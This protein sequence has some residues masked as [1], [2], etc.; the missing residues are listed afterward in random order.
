MIHHDE[1]HAWAEEAGFDGCGITPAT[2]LVE[3]QQ[4]FDRWL[5]AGHHA[6]LDYLTRH[7]D[8]RF[9]PSLLI[10]GA[11]SVVVCAVS[12]KNTIS[13]GYPASSRT[14]VA[15]YACNRDYHHTFKAMLQALLARIRA[16]HPEVTGRAF[17][18]TAPLAE[19]S[20]A[21]E[22]GLGW[23][24]RNSLLISP[25]WGSFL[26]LGELV[27]TTEADRYDRPFGE[28][29]C[30][31]CRACIEHCP[32]GAILD[33]ERMIDASRCIACHT[34][35]RQPDHAINLDGWIFGC[36]ACQ[37]PC[38][39]NRHAPHHR[40]SQF[41]PLFDPRAWDAEAW[42]QLDDAAFAEHFGSTP[43][44][45]AGLERIRENSKQ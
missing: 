19:K 39:Y 2:R 42:Q 37:Q 21:V 17:V 44:V 33:G 23:I 6:S 8:K 5:T 43:L 34:I 13:E 26:H 9:D 24:G 29:R 41:D 32:T 1:I 16:A 35:E 45:R 22:A 12:Y 20:L 7:A 11:R 27:L 31:T 10:E 38:P 28:G 4:R 30:G 14:K 15:S 36:D 3:A 25:R 40:N 18:D